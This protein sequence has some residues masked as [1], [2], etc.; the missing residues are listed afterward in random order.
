MSKGLSRFA[1]SL[2]L[3]VYATFLAAAAPIDEPR[4]TVTNFYGLYIK[5]RPLGIP[6]QS[7]LR[8]L[9][10]YLS[11]ALSQN[12]KQALAAEQRYGKKNKN[13]VPPL[14]EGDIFSS[15][16]EGATG[17]AVQSCETKG[18]SATCT[19]SF[20]RDN[21]DGK[22]PTRWQDRVYLLH[23]TR[24]WKIDDIVYL[25]DWQFMHKGRLKELLKQVIEEGSKS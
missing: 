1:W 14:V 20:T 2:V 16:F 10:P 12:L 17:F 24:G 9:E 11:S 22:T 6:N 15:L 19:M 7:D 18:Q 13:E 4:R 3:V 8:K 5:V 25:G 21:R 23:E